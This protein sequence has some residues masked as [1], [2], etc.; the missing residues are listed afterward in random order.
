[1]IQIDIP[2]KPISVNQAFRAIPRGNFCTS[3]KSKE[4]RQFESDM[5]KLLPKKP[6]IKGEIAVTIEFH[7]KNRYSVI[8][9]DNLGKPAIDCLAT[10]GYFENDKYI[11]SL[12]LSKYKALEDSI[13]VIITEA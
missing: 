4:Y 1:M 8:D 10:A 9:V 7:L 2:I 5:S 13:K 3:I 11:T 12:N 6:M